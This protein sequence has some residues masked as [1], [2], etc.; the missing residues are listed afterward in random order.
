[1]D[2]TESPEELGGTLGVRGVDGLRTLKR[3]RERK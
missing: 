2:E 1:M 3:K